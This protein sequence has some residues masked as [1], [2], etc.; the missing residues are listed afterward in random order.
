MP[1]FA[2]Q[3]YA[4]AEA[5]AADEYD[6][7]AA[8]KAPSV[9]QI[10]DAFDTALEVNGIKRLGDLISTARLG[11]SVLGGAGRP[12]AS[13]RPTTRTSPGSPTSTTD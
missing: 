3:G 9:P 12:P 7:G 8:E 6:P 1:K 5:M 2:F 4:S 13:A 10:V 11:Q